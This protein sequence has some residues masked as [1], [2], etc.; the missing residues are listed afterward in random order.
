MKKAFNREK[1]LKYSNEL[2][3]EISGSIETAFSKEIRLRDKATSSRD[4]KQDIWKA[5]ETNLF[6]LSTVF[7]PES[8]VV[9]K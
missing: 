8:R 4:R 7:S 1:I 9:A 3:Y 5:D 6:S 2:E